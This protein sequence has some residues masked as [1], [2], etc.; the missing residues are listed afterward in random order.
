MASERDTRW[1]LTGS[2]EVC[3]RKVAGLRQVQ[4]ERFRHFEK[5][6]NARGV[7]LWSAAPVGRTLWC[8]SLTDALCVAVTGMAALCRLPCCLL[9]LSAAAALPSRPQPRQPTDS[10]SG[11][12]HHAA[13][14]HR[15]QLLASMTWRSTDQ[16]PV[17]HGSTY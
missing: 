17:L 10:G 11:A 7:R 8:G 13:R 15:S 1:M 3:R 6:C 5:A 9:H 4:R 2:G 12:H 14:A 16:Q